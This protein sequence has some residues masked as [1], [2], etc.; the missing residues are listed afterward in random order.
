MKSSNEFFWNNLFW[1]AFYSLI[2]NS[3]FIITL[4]P[5]ADDVWTFF[6]I[7]WLL[8]ETIMYIGAIIYQV[9]HDGKID[10]ILKNGITKTFYNGICYTVEEMHNEGSILY[11]FKVSIYD[12]ECN[13]K[14]E[15]NYM[16]G[17]RY[18]DERIKKM[19][20]L[21]EHGPVE[22]IIEKNHPELHHI[23]LE[24]LLE[25]DVNIYGSKKISLRRPICYLIVI[26]SIIVSVA[27]V[28]LILIQW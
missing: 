16:F 2:M 7:L 20:E 21:L 19:R 1:I 14:Y 27:D 9:R 13:Q 23:M 26:A 25:N 24:K 11:N 17:V 22:V 8:L 3:F 12:M 28:Y 15:G 10:K 18:G 6:A 5:P 4:I